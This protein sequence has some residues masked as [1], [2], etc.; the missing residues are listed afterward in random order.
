MMIEGSQVSRSR[1]EFLKWI[2]SGMASAALMPWLPRVT[3]TASA[4]AMPNI[5]FIL[6]DDLGW[7]D[8][9]CYGNPAIKTPGLD[10]LA[11]EGT[12][13]TQFYANSPVCSPSRTSFMT[14]Q[15]PARYSIHSYLFDDPAENKSRGMPNFL[16]PAALML[17]RLLQGAGYATAH[18]GKWHLGSTPNAPSP[19]VYGIGVH[20]TLISSGG[21][22]LLSRKDRYYRAKSTNVMIDEAI[23]FILE[24]KALNRPF[25]MNLWSLI[26]HATL[27]PTPE[28]LAPF[29]KLAPSPRL[30]YHGA[31]KV[32]FASVCDLDR[33]IERLLTKLD[34][35]GLT[36]DTIVIFSSDNGPEDIHVQSVSHSAYG[37]TGPFRGRKRSLY[38]GGV[39]M[40]F[41]VRWPEHVPASRVDNTSVVS[42]V[43]LLPTLCSIVGRTIRE[44]PPLD[45]EDVRHILEGSSRSRTKP[46]FWEYRFEA[47]MDPI[48]RSPMAAIRDGDWKLLAN[49]DRSRMELYNIPADPSEC[50]NMAA[51]NPILV[52]AL[53]AQ[54]TAWQQTLPAGPVSPDAGSN[55]Y[56]WPGM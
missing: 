21:P 22:K 30:P 50:N 13:F 4:A 5:I 17:S 56:P 23:R 46:L 18:F 11:A 10:R 41:L 53:F 14:G 6:A 54:L 28:Q 16:S 34:K 12:L 48:H 36:N 20:K 33:Q 29:A 25:Y 7:G 47:H 55:S 24:C 39:R 45:G 38:E 49:P 8:L 35:L 31:K 37:S 15:F 32:Y 9:S 51:A 19:G 1:R 26:P 42:A 44:A 52:E 2:A 27:N 3:G 40:P 43:D